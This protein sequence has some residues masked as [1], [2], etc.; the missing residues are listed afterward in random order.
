MDAI[1]FLRQKGI[2]SEDK[3][4]WIIKFKDGKEVDLVKL[5]EEY[6]NTKILFEPNL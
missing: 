6:Y 2:L 4:Q 3:T 1:M 5:F